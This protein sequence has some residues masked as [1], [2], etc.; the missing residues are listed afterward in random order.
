[1]SEITTEAEQLKTI[2]QLIATLPNKGDISDGYHTFDELYQHRCILYIAL[3]KIVN[4]TTIATEVWR[5]KKHSD[6]TFWEGWFLLG[7]NTKEGQQMTYHL[8]MG[9]W[10]ET[11]F[12]RDRDMAPYF[13]GHTPSDVLD[14]I[15]KL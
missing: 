14:R 9:L 13:D 4:R 3:A 10:D 8:P 7:I 15:I 11:S 12:A 1:M 5:S 2:N 6:G